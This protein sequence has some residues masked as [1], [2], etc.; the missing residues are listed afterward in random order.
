MLQQQDDGVLERLHLLE[1]LLNLVDKT[2]AAFLQLRLSNH[3]Q[4]AWEPAGT[5]Q[6]NPNAARFSGPEQ[7]R[8][9]FRPCRPSAR[10][11]AHL[12]R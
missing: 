7:V 9:R 12:T 6:R 4:E 8:T 1:E 2:F 3:R 5:G 11:A 10:F